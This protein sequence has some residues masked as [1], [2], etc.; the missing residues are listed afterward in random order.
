M[1]FNY[2]FSALDAYVN[3]IREAD[4]AAA[5]ANETNNSSKKGKKKGTSGTVQ[6]K[7]DAGS[8]K[9]KG[10]TNQGVDRLK[11]ANTDGMKKISSFFTPKK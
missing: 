3:T 8:K 9:R 6:E 4:A 7:E 10:A 5:A 11:K 2:S 1:N